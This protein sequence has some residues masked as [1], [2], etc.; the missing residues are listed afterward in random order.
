M[1]PLKSRLKL[2]DTR[3][4]DETTET[5]SIAGGG[6]PCSSPRSTQLDGAAP[7][8]LDQPP[9]V[10]TQAPSHKYLA[11]SVLEARNLVAKDYDTHSSDP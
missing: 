10:R 7:L 3:K 9:F 4:T 8:L 2:R 5:M 11:I 6:S 1:F